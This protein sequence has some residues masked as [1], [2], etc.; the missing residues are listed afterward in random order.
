MLYCSYDALLEEKQGL[1]ETLMEIK[2]DFQKNGKTAVS[3]EVSCV[4]ERI[5]SC[6]DRCHISQVR[7]LKR[8]VQNL[9]L[10]M[11]KE[12]NRFQ[13]AISKKSTEVKRLNNE[14]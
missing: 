9:E 8:V 12:K 13:R 10:E 5:V 11:M 14:V 4:T 6:S 3:K 1:E 7:I 2:E